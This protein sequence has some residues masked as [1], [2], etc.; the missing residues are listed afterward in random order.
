M[1]MMMILMC[2]A[3]TRAFIDIILLNVQN[4]Q[5]VVLAPHVLIGG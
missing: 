1:I 5:P 4:L 3:G 2:T